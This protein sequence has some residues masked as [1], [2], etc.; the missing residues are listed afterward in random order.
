MRKNS[1][2][3]LKLRRRLGEKWKSK[4]GVFKINDSCGANN[5][6]NR[7]SKFLSNLIHFRLL[8]FKMEYEVEKLLDSRINKSLV[9][10]SS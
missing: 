10:N 3:S 1:H 4:K 2:V 7:N 5:A 8:K 6:D 9:I